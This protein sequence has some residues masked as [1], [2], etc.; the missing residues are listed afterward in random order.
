MP[1]AFGLHAGFPPRHSRT[2]ESG[3]RAQIARR[4]HTFGCRFLTRRHDHPAIRDRQRTPLGALAHAED[5]DVSVAFADSAAAYGE[6][7]A[8]GGS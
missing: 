2:G 7:G 8:G 3:F 6:G 4:A 5:S 1:G